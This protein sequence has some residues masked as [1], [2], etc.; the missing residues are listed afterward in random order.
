MRGVIQFVI[1]TEHDLAAGDNVQRAQ[2]ATDP[3]EVN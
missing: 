3:S 1:D 2:D